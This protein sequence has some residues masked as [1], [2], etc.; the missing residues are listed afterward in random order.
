MV[1]SILLYK[2]MKAIDSHMRESNLLMLLGFTPFWI[3]HHDAQQSVCSLW[4]QGAPNPVI[5]MDL[6]VALV[7][8]QAKL[9]TAMP[10]S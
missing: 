4:R 5:T 8:Q 2:F 6:V 1:Y 3:T 10:E 9:V 7:A